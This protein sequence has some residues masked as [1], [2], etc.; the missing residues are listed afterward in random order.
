MQD[1]STYHEQT[2]GGTNL[3]ELSHGCQFIPQQLQCV[4][5]IFKPWF[6]LSPPIVQYFQILLIQINIQTYQRL[7]CEARVAVEDLGNTYNRS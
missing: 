4:C 3:Q 5:N 6:S 2:T 7:G 1:R